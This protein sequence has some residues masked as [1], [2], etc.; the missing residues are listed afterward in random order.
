MPLVLPLTD[1]MEGDIEDLAANQAEAPPAGAEQAGAPPQQTPLHPELE[2]IVTANCRTEELRRTA[3]ELMPCFTAVSAWC[4]QTLVEEH[5]VPVKHNDAT[6]LAP[7]TTHLADAKRGGGAQ[8]TDV[9]TIVAATATAFSGA[10][11]QHN[12]RAPSEATGRQITHAAVHKAATSIINTGKVAEKGL[13]PDADRHAARRVL[14][15]DLLEAI[16]NGATVT[17]MNDG[18]KDK[19]KTFA[20]RF[21]PLRRKLITSQDMVTQAVVQRELRAMIAGL[22]SAEPEPMLWTSRP[23]MQALQA[24]C[25]ALAMAFC[26]GSS[27]QLRLFLLATHGTLMHDSASEFSHGNT[28]ETQMKQRCDWS[29]IA[30][31]MD[32]TADGRKEL[33]EKSMAQEA[34]PMKMARTESHSDRWHHPATGSARHGGGGGGFMD[35][36]KFVEQ[37]RAEVTTDIS[38]S[39][40]EGLWCR[41][42]FAVQPTD[43]ALP[44]AS[45]AGFTLATRWLFPFGGSQKYRD[46]Q[47]SRFKES[48]SCLICGG[49]GHKGVDCTNYGGIAIGEPWWKLMELAANAEKVKV[50][51][52]QEREGIKATTPVTFATS[53]EIRRRVW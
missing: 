39:I 48:G 31:A 29:P 50:I 21:Q 37:K 35:K 53:F 7:I 49:M 6:L 28:L 41:K 23:G 25:E 17:T 33:N 38:K 3:R 32:D 11:Q 45:E 19:F 16:L 43:G 42:P 34:P 20:L 36:D 8:A 24:L 26:L 2:A 46:N 4:F 30:D 40:S 47:P 15:A 44:P 27:F 12:A 18:E 1:A 14:L 5:P 52:P 22:R 13:G 9:A 10:L 51:I